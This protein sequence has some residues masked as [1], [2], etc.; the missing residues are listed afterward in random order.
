VVS[1]AGLFERLGASARVVVVSA[2]PGSGKTVLLH[3]WITE[4]GLAERAAWVSVERDERDPQRFWVSV[5]GALRL[6]TLGAGL[7]RPLAAAPDLD[8]WAGGGAAVEGSG[9]AGGPGLAGAR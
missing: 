6:M 7:V 8:G 2:P 1:R 4:A 5:A 9:A 3:S